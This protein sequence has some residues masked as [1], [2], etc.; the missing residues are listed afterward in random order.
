[1][2]L[3]PYARYRNARRE[4]VDLPHEPGDF[5]TFTDERG[6]LWWRCAV[7]TGVYASAADAAAEL[8][9]IEDEQEAADKAA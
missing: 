5:R 7:T 4:C 6:R 1:M 3:T 8:S 9:F 2:E